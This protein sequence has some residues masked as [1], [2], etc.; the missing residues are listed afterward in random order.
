VEKYGRDTQ[1]ADDS[2]IR[3]MRFACRLNKARIQ[4][5]IYTI[6]TAVVVTRT[7]LSIT[8]YVHCVSCFVD[9][10]E[11]NAIMNMLVCLGY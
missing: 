10:F 3:C 6:Y 8:L 7:R 4:T 2:T 1:A 5:H 11:N 9:V